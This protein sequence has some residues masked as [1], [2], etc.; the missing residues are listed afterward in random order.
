MRMDE[1]ASA[2][3]LPY[4]PRADDRCCEFDEQAEPLETKIPSEER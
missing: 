3:L 2:S 4:A 1:S